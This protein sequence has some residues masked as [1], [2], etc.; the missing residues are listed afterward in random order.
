MTTVYGKIISMI[1]NGKFQLKRMDKQKNNTN[2][3][4]PPPPT[5][6]NKNNN[7][8]QT[9]TTTRTTT[10]TP[11]VSSFVSSGPRSQV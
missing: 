1:C 11:F 10:T 3:Q 2:I 8:E 7:K 5:S 9:T 6:N 4:P